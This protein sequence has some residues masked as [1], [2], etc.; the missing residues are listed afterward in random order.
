[1]TAGLVWIETFEWKAPALAVGAADYGYSMVFR[2]SIASRMPIADV[3]GDKNG[4]ATFVMLL[5]GRVC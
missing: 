5:N 3:M 1:L 2:C 4:I